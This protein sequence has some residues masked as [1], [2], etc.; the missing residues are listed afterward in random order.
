MTTPG[1]GLGWIK[2][3]SGNWVF[4]VFGQ[5]LCVGM[6]ADPQSQSCGP[7]LGVIST[8]FDEISCQGWREGRE[9]TDR[10]VMI[11][12]RSNGTDVA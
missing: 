8:D 7:A 3:R 9:N 11:A 12:A 5:F 4:S 2:S 10:S 1:E 6:I